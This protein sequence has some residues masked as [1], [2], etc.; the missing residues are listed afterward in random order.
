MGKLKE[1][2]IRA[3]RGAA[4]AEA[5]EGVRVKYLGRKGELTGLLRALKDLPVA[6]RKRIGP[7]ANVL[8]RELE[9]LVDSKKAELGGNEGNRVHLDVTKPGEKL[10]RGHLHPLTRIDKDIRDIFRSMNFSVVEGPEVETAYYNFDALNIP[11]D[12]PA[13]DMWDT[14]WLQS[15]QK[16]SKFEIRNSKFL[17][18]SQ[19]LLLR[20]HTSPVQVRYMETHEPPFQI[21]VPGRVF[22]YE[23]T[24][25]SHEINFYQLEGLMVG[26]D[27]SLA[28]FKFVVEEF[29]RK[30]FGKGLEFRFRPGYFPFV[31]PGLEVDIKL[32]RDQ[33][34]TTNDSRQSSVVSRQSDWLEVMGAG[35]V[36]RNV[37]DAV[38]YNPDA[39]HGFAFGMGIDRLA[40]IKYKVPDIRLFY[41]GDLR[42][43]RQF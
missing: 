19:Q 10:R 6:E 12:H 33:R 8:R 7:A 22:R 31:E 16:N 29:F 34:Q 4:D 11:P 27:V 13:R 1:E 15:N 38:H 28:N 9:S 20:T 3:L 18:K 14:L 35:M 39:V 5:L 40:M 23:A 37:F 32:T 21:V 24:D 26:E 36:H 2:A 42:F 25:A 17:N 43:I 41:N 30:L